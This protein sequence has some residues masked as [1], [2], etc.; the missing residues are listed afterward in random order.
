IYSFIALFFVY[1]EFGIDSKTTLLF[2]TACIICFTPGFVP[3]ELVCGGNYPDIIPDASAEELALTIE[4]RK[5]L[6]TEGV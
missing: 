4:K 5:R 6:Q 2:R 1:T 3:G